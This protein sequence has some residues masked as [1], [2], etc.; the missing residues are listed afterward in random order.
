MNR[1]T[2]LT[3]IATGIAAGCAG[4]GVPIP[5]GY[6]AYGVPSSRYA[7]YEIADTVVIETTTPEGRVIPVTAASSMKLR[8]DIWKASGMKGAVTPSLVAQ[9]SASSYRRMRVSGYVRSFEATLCSPLTG[10][11]SGDIDDVSGNLEV[12]LSP[13]GVEER[14][15]FPALSGAAAQASLFPTLA[16]ALFP[17]LP[18]VWVEPGGTWV[19]TVTVTDDGEGISRTTTSISTHTLVGDTLVG[20]R[21]LVHIRV[22]SKV[23]VERVIEE[24]GMEGTGIVTGTVN[25]SVLWDPRLRLVA[26]AEYQRDSRGTTTRRGETSGTDMTMSGPTRIW[27]TG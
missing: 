9:G 27:L 2:L 10:D 6:L 14:N 19:D 4:F 22:A 5:T 21:M 17:R 18:D 15:A 13:H 8:L 26:Y 25:G 20:G 11:T 7:T 3:I 24:A 16:D 23:T 12:L 1:R